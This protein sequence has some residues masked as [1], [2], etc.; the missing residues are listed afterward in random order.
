MQQIQPLSN[1]AKCPPDFIIVLEILQ[2]SENL[3]LQPSEN[4]ASQCGERRDNEKEEEKKE[5]GKVV[6]ILFLHD[7]RKTA[8]HDQL[9]MIQYAEFY[10]QWRTSVLLALY[11]KYTNADLNI[12][13]YVPIYVK[14]ISSKCF[15][16]NPENYRVIHP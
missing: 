3:I 12:S 13:L 8:I 5:T 10:N 15:I 9:C 1:S 7:K 11:Q 14:I 6:L 16:L 4:L 2:P